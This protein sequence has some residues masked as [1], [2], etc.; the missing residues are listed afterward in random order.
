MSVDGAR[1]ELRGEG[2]CGNADEEL[3]RAVEALL[4]RATE[5]LAVPSIARALDV[6]AGAARRAVGALAAELEAR[7]S[8]L[9]VLES[10][11]GVR[12]ATRPPYS[13]IAEAALERERR[14]RLSDAALETLAIVAY[15]QPV[16]RVEIQKLRGV[17]PDSSL[18]TLK[19]LGLV[20]ETADGY[21]TTA[22]FLDV[23]GLRSLGELPPLEAGEPGGEER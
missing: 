5:P 16:R 22:R 10:G 19:E 14:V 7:G 13:E 1:G 3:V 23:V 2:A 17:N 11:A 18:A 15:R 9:C 21:V 6:P 8:A 4:F 12:L 20:E